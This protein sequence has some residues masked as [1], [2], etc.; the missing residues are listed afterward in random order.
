[1]SSPDPAVPSMRPTR[2]PGPTSSPLADPTARPQVPS[3]PGEPDCTDLVASLSLREQVGQLL[4]VGVP[5]FGISAADERDLARIRA[6]SVV[7][8]GNTEAGAEVVEGVTDRARSAAGRPAGIRLLVAADQE[9]GQVQ[10][11]RGPGFRDIPSAEQQAGLPSSELVERASRWGRDLRSAGVDANLAPV[12]DVVPDD[13]R[14]V[15]EP[16]GLLR[17]GY[18]SDPNRVADKVTAFVTGM[19]RADRATAVKHFPGLGRVR[20]NTDFTADVV[21]DSTRRGG[22]DLLGFRAAVVAGTD[23]VMMSSA[24]YARIDAEHRAAYS[25]EII[26]EMLRG[27]LRFAGVVISDDLAAVA[28]GDLTPRSRLLR[29]LR[30]G[31]D[32]AIVGDP[33]MAVAAA[34]AV[35]AD[36]RDDDGLAELVA[37][38]AAR[39]LRLKARYGLAKC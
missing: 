7:L 39:V 21:D 2:T 3:P 32:L 1:M 5:S 37:D 8:L 16:I 19:Q 9:G 15:N 22:E 18:G 4:M 6:G 23:M 10:R 29:F 12:A 17:R 33:D 34:D 26:E 27:D 14:T 11:L 30:A 25:A 36:A 35:V 20:G 13:M 38:R 24:R 28:M 31:G